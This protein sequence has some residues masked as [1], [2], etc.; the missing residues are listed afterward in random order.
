MNRKFH[1]WIMAGAAVILTLTGCIPVTGGTMEP[2]P[3]P[4]QPNELLQVITTTLIPLALGQSPEKAAAKYGSGEI[5]MRIPDMLNQGKKDCV[6]IFPF[7]VIKDTEPYTIKGEGEVHCHFK[8]DNTNGPGTMHAVMEHDV[9]VGGS[10]KPG[11]TGEMRLV[12]EL[13]F[14]GSLKNYVTDLPADVINPF[15]EANPFVW[16]D[17][18]PLIL[19]FEYTDGAKVTDIRSNP[20]AGD[21]AVASESTRLFIL[22]LEK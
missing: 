17:S 10:I 2:S 5:E 7:K 14:G 15:T 22:H 6:N 13:A 20:M 21:S 3:T 4:T 8:A 16:D 11:E 1:T 12:V 9:V 18:G 19:N